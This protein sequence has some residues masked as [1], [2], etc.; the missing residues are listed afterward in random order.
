M[1]NR[2][3]P[4][5]TSLLNPLHS[6]CTK[7][8]NPPWI[9]FYRHVNSGQDTLY[10]RCLHHEKMRLN[11]FTEH[12][13]KPLIHIEGCIYQRSPPVNNATD[14]LFLFEGD[15]TVSVFF[16]K[17]KFVSICTLCYCETHANFL[18]VFKCLELIL[19]LMGQFDSYKR[20]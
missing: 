11:V 12:T 20:K 3:T 4:I 18:P 9:V 1:Q 10:I 5:G 15:H 2:W 7:P 6:K 13:G 8:V 14:G 19:R 16:S 17:Y